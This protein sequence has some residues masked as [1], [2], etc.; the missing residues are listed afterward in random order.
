MSS[1]S[2]PSASVLDDAGFTQ[3]ARTSAL[4]RSDRSQGETAHSFRQFG[5]ERIGPDGDPA[6]IGGRLARGTLYWND[7][8]STIITV[9]AQKGGVG[10]SALST[11]IAA[12][13][14]RRGVPT[15]LVDADPQGSSIHWI[16]LRGRHGRHLRSDVDAG[17]PDIVRARTSGELIRH[18]DA[19]RLRHRHGDPV[20]VIDTPPR[21]DGSVPAA[22]RVADLAIV[23]CG[24]S[25]LDRASVVETLELADQL[26]RTAV[27]LLAR[28]LP[29]RT[30]LD[31]TVVV[32]P[33]T[34]RARELLE[35]D[36][37]T[38]ADQT[39]TERVVWKAASAVG[40]TV[41]EHSRHTPAARELEALVAELCDAQG[42]GDGQSVRM[43]S[44]AGM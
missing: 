37:A 26:D 6:A 3:D 28:V 25:E 39:L 40:L 31:G 29:D 16:S 33:G 20:I 27:V 12:S 11:A 15:L 36:G 1:G 21:V 35:A 34:R 17:T 7:P 23:P 22:I 32:S 8:M 41:A 19:Y 24:P 13:I 4:V 18:L 42:I 5:G 10:K 38:V 2:V 9:A 30:L 43:H 44:A 14:R